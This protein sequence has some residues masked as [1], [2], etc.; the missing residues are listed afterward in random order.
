MKHEMNNKMSVH[1]YIKQHKHINYCEAII[2]KDGLIIDV[3]PNH[4]QTLIRETGLSQDE[5]NT[6]M[7]TS[8]SPIDW[9]VDYTGC[10]A[11][12]YEGVIIPTTGF[13]KKQKESALLLVENNI[14]KNQIM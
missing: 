12:W 6:M 8:C 13:T 7:P 9:L 10:I 11:V 1:E 4:I 2:D 5:I 3:K 14:I